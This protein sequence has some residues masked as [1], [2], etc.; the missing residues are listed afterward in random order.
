MVGKKVEIV[1][2]GHVYEVTEWVCTQPL[3]KS[4]IALK[5]TLCE[6]LNV[7]PLDFQAKFEE[8]EYQIQKFFS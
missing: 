6:L 1:L 7:H 3:D 2:D 5:L 8:K 4:V